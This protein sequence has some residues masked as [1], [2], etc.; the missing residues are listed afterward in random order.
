MYHATNS[1][2][3]RLNCSFASRTSEIL[4]KTKQSDFLMAMPPAFQAKALCELGT[5]YSWES[6]VH[7]G[8]LPDKAQTDYPFFVLM[9]SALSEQCFSFFENVKNK[10]KT[11]SEQNR[12]IWLPQR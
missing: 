8:Y 4:I 10:P 9:G 5:C 3:S 2:L 7:V 11:G 6:L 1:Q 12:N